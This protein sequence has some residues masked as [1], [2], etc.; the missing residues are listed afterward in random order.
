VTGSI[1]GPVDVS[2]GDHLFTGLVPYSNYRIIVVAENA[3]G[4]SVRQRTF[5]T[6]FTCDSP[7]ADPAAYP[8]QAGDGSLQILISS[9]LLL[10]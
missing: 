5:E 7:A 6:T 9:V 8:F 3:F 10:S 2:S 1:Q 4:S